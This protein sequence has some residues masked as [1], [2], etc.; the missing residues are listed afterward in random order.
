[1]PNFKY[2][3]KDSSGKAIAGSFEAIDYA[4]AVDMLRKQ[5]LIIVSV[6]EAAAKSNIFSMSFSQKKVK[7]D[8]LVVFRGNWPPW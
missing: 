4:S 7:T 6:N 1:M 5:G 2:T 3:A 8:D